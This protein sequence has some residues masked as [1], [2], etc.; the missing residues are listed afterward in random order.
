[1]TAIRLTAILE[2]KNFVARFLDYAVRILYASIAA[3]VL[4]DLRLSG[5]LWS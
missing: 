3:I 5:L 4:S 2:R 1:M